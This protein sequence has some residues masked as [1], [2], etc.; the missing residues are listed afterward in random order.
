MARRVH[1]SVW[2]ARAGLAL[3]PVG[4][5][6]PPVRAELRVESD[7]AGIRVTATN[8]PLGEV[9][10]ALKAKFPLRYGDIA[11]DRDVTGTIEG[12]LHRVVVRLL[13]GFDFVV[14]RSGDGVEIVKVA[15]C[16]TASFTPPARRGATERTIPAEQA[17]ARAAAGPAAAQAPR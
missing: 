3:A 8:A 10:A 12:T 13:D 17:A 2:M 5:L 6:A 4:A 11:V 16:G 9:L 14:S 1:V 7:A 15:P